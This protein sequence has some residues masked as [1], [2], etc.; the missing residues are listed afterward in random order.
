MSLLTDGLIYGY[1]RIL[2]SLGASA[3]LRDTLKFVGFT[4]TDDDVNQVTVITGSGGGGAGFGPTIDNG[5]TGAIN[6]AASTA[7]G[8]DAGGIR[9]TGAAPALA[10]VDPGSGTSRLLNVVAYGG[11]LIVRNEG[12]GA[13]PSWRILTGTGA[14]VTYPQGSSI[15]LA[16]D[17]LSSRWR[18]DSGSSGGASPGGNIGDLQTKL[19]PSTF[20]GLTAADGQF[21]RRVSSAWAAYNLIPGGSNN[22]AVGID[23]SG[24]LKNLGPLPPGT[25]PPTGTGFAHVTTGA[26]DLASKKVDLSAS[27]DVQG[28]LGVPN[29]GT[30]LT[31][32]SLAGQS[33]KAMAV[34]V[35]ENGFVFVTLSGGGGGSPSV[36]SAGQSNQSDGLGGWS[37]STSVYMGTGGASW[38]TVGIGN[39]APTANGV[40]IANAYKYQCKNPG[41]GTSSLIWMDSSG[42]VFVGENSGQQASLSIDAQSGSSINLRIAGVTKFWAGGSSNT[43]TVGLIVTANFVQIGTNPASA[44]FGLCLASTLGVSWRNATNTADVLGLFTDS[45]NNI[46]LGDNVNAPTTRVRALT[47]FWIDIGGTITAKVT[48]TIFN[49]TTPIAFTDVSGGTANAGSG[50]I[51]SFYNPGAI[52]ATKDSGGNDRNV[53]NQSSNALTFGPSATMTSA[54]NGVSVSLQVAGTDKVALGTEFK[55]GVPMGGLS[56]PLTFKRTTITF[57]GADIPLSNAQAECPI[58]DLSG[59][60]GDCLAPD[61]TGA[62]FIVHNSSQP[63]GVRKVGSGSGGV[64]FTTP[65]LTAIIYHNGTNYTLAAAVTP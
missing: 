5:A 18:V 28:T 57:A 20:A 40:S 10:G 14:D 62:V 32:A 21:V 35:S 53:I 55:I 26:Y 23:G 49:H 51:R 2:D 3:P 65:S 50:Q 25:T 60:T 17:P 19:G 58:L 7:S 33:G 52:V 48:S 46:Y 56:N 15:L 8:A 59:S 61:V 41:G 13:T 44:S 30:G 54:L 42:N 29:G 39:S 16:L 1:R 27:A 6:A 45:S 9:F 43:S 36:G 64:A 37:A 31:T 24:N 12:G 11:P 34:N 22:D 4:V 38:V 63:R 47:N